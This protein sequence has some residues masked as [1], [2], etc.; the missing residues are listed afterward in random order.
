MLLFDAP[1]DL[2]RRAALKGATDASP[3]QAVLA[4]QSRK[5]SARTFRHFTE[6]VLGRWGLPEGE[7]DSAVLIVS[8]L[9]ANAAQHGCASTTLF[10]FHDQETLCIEVVDFGDRLQDGCERADDDDP[11]EHGRG[12]G[13][14]ECLAQWIEVRQN[15]DG[16]TVRVGM[17]GAAGC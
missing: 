9:T 8:E 5:A 16:R 11:A 13:I 17:R 7:R 6:D 14:V 1:A 10:L 3:Q 2:T 12:M 15:R 4:L